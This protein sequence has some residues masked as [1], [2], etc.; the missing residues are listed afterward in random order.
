M[1]DSD[2]NPSI[3]L[4]NQPRNPESGSPSGPS[5]GPLFLLATQLVTGSL[6]HL[7]SKQHISS[8]FINTTIV[9]FH[10]IMFA[11][12]SA[13]SSVLL[14]LAA[15]SSVNAHGAMVAVTGS[16]GV[17]GQGFGIVE[18]TPRDGTRRQ[19]FQTDTS[20]I[21]DREIAS[22][23]SASSAG[24]PAA[25]EDG[26]VTM[27][28]HQINGDG[29]GPYTCGVSADASGKS[30]A[31]MKILT[32]VPGENSRSNAKATDFPLVAQMPAGTTCTGGP[33]GDACVVRCRNAAR[34]GPFGGCT[35]VTNAVG[36]AGNSTAP[37]A[38]SAPKAAGAK[39]S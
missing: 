10:S 39:A 33:N 18:T 26:T 16:N 28:I 19:P 22:D 3:T 37:A 2:D 14:V 36:G 24:L 35:A 21:R 13:I 4:D 17:T 1:Q 15:I 38:A 25:S 9:N 12:T 34:A 23:G 29:A 30:F 31:D 27:T 20:I 8:N 7:I 6:L 11:K 5:A 32:N